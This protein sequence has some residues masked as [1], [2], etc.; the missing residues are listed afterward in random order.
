MR[1]SHYVFHLT[2]LL[3]LTI[4]SFFKDAGLIRIYQ[5]KLRFVHFLQLRCQFLKS[6]KE[7]NSDPLQ[8]AVIINDASGVTGWFSGSSL[9]SSSLFFIIM[10]LTAM[11]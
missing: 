5:L 9:L 7:L 1:D 6:D 11:V 2:V 4:T 3:Q 10:F 8:R